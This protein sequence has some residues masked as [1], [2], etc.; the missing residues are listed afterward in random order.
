MTLIETAR[1][2]LADKPSDLRQIV[3][4]LIQE[5]EKRGAQHIAWSNFGSSVF[6]NDPK[7]NDH[8]IKAMA[9]Q[10]ELMKFARELTEGGIQ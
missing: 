8:K 4:E 3:G 9:E 7:Y 10:I 6:R 2:L 1:T 5:A